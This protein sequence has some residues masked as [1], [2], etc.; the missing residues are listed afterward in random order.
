[1]INLTNKF[2]KNSHFIIL[3]NKTI[4]NNK[5]KPYSNYHIILSNL[6][7]LFIS[8]TIMNNNNSGLSINKFSLNN[9]IGGQL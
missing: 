9:K 6:F 4:I 3:T 7:S 5:I 2:L 1:M 8:K